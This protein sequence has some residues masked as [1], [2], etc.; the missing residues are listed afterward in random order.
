MAVLR[1][2]DLNARAGSL[3]GLYK[4][5]FVFVRYDHQQFQKA[6]L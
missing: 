1:K 5:E 2:V 3:L 4:D 6:S